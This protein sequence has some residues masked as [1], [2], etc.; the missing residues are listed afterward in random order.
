MKALD[1]IRKILSTFSHAFAAVSASSVSK[2]ATV[3]SCLHLCIAPAVAMR[4]LLCTVITILR[5]D[6]LDSIMVMQ[7]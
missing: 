3:L 4:A 6:A 5:M 1:M 2:G 7:Q